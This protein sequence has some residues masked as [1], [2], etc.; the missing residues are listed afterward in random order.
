MEIDIT[1]SKLFYAMTLHEL[2]CMNQ[3]QLDSSLSYN[4]YLYLCLLEC[5]RGLT[6]S[7]IANL[8]QVAKSAVTLKVK[9]LEKLGLVEK[10]QSK[11]DKRVYHLVITKKGIQMYQSYDLRLAKAYQRLKKKY[12]EK[13]I[14]IFN[15]ML[16]DY[17]VFLEEE[18]SENE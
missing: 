17:S 14:T 12:N 7:D 3:N 9:E 15:S 2:Q 1:V 16:Y 18:V 8:L 11:D 6:V 10:V 13:E 5:K 4:S